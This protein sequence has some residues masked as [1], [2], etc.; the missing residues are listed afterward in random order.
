MPVIRFDSELP[1]RRRGAVHR[2]IHRLPPLS[3]ICFNIAMEDFPRRCDGRQSA[4][5][6]PH[7]LTCRFQFTVIGNTKYLPS[8][9]RALQLLTH[10]SLT[11][12]PYEELGRSSNVRQ[13][14]LGVNLHGRLLAMACVAFAAR[15]A[16]ISPTDAARRYCASMSTDLIVECGLIDASWEA[17]AL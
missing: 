14:L 1:R 11:S 7:P 16:A 3:K 8:P 13:T 6:K 15:H 2:R 10:I 17:L 4:R 5:R 12:I 9:L